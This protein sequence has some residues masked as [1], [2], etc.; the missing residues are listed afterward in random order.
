M[1]AS[2]IQQC[3]VSEE[4]LRV[5]KL[6]CQG[7]KRGKKDVEMWDIPT[8]KEVAVTFKNSEK[9]QS[10]SE[11]EE[12]EDEEVSGSSSSSY[13]LTSDRSDSEESLGSEDNNGKE[14]E[15]ETDP[16]PEAIVELARTG[17]ESN[18][19]EALVGN[20]DKPRTR[21]MRKNRK[22]ELL[23]RLGD[24]EQKEVERKSRS[25]ILR[26]GTSRRS[27]DIPVNVNKTLN[28]SAPAPAPAQTNP[29]A[30]TNTPIQRTRTQALLNTA[31][32]DYLLKQSAKL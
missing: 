30:T 29:P 25:Q 31:V 17:S 15:S 4:G 11:S 3:R 5:V 1:G 6:F 18:A 7:E 12:L 21:T 32:V 2:L 22:Q 16:S 19:E 8:A 26:R 24:I 10:E 13:E 23:D 9:S 20:D 28:A 14:E 27:H